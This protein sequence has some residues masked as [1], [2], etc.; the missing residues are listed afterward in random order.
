M[1][2]DVSWRG[3]AKRY[4]DLYRGGA[5]PP[6]ERGRKRPSA[7]SSTAGGLEAA[8]DP[9]QRG[10][11]RLCLF[12]GDRQVFARRSPAGPTASSAASRRASAAGA[13]YGFR[14]DGPFDPARGHRFDAS[15]LL[16][17]PYAFAFDR[18]F[19]LHPSMFKFGEDSGRSRRRRSP[20]RRRPANLAAQRVA[21]EALVI[22]ELNLRGFTR[23]NPAIPEALRGTFAGLAHPASIAHLAALGVTAVEIMPADAF[24]DERHLAAARARNAWG[25]N[26]VV[27]GAPD[28]RLAP[29]GWAEVRA[30][31]D[32]LHARRH[33]GHSRRR[34]QPQRRERR[35]SGRPF[36]SAASTTRPSSVSIPES[37]AITSTT[38]GPA[39]ASRSTD[40]SSSTMAIGALRR[41]MV[42]R[43]LRRVPLRSRDRA[44]PHARTASTRTRRSSRRWRKTR[45]S[46]EARLIAEPWDI[47]PGGYQLGRFG[48]AFAEWN[49]N[50]AT[51]RGASGAA[52]RAARRDRDPHRRLA[53]RLRRCRKRRRRASI[54]SSRMT[55]SPSPTSSPTTGSTTRP[56][57]KEIATAPTPI[58]L[59]P[60]R[61]GAERRSGDDRRAGARRAQSADPSHG[62]ARDADA[63]RWARNSASA[64]A[65]TT[66][67]I[68][69]T[70]RRARSTGA[71]PTRRSPIF[72]AR[73][74]AARR[75][76]P[77]LSRDAFLTGQPF[78][79][80]RSSRR[81]MARRR[82][83]D[84]RSG[85]ERSGG[86][87]SG[88]GLRRAGRGDGVDRAA[89][90]MNRADADTT[91]V[92]P[93]AARRHGVAHAPR[94]RTIQRRRAPARARRP[95]H[96]SGA[97]SRSFSPRRRRRGGCAA[98]RPAA[99]IDALAGAVGIAPDWWDVSGARTFVSPETKI[100]LLGALGLAAA[101]EA[102]ARDSLA[103][104]SR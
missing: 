65:A 81:R 6:H 48:P 71:A 38:P 31:T 63:R 11:R 8:L 90:A 93:A 74:I 53:R 28:P 57:A 50:F 43:R 56:T 4:A 87:G 1:R 9:A 17:D 73:L 25:Y 23:L 51:R 61:R 96:G 42:L 103:R 94:H 66:T 100:A 101:S 102:E 18:P 30:A 88:R 77:A 98:A 84:D 40:R 49:D 39:I 44:R 46:R 62:L 72:T 95:P 10:R 14:V 80:C 47:G 26:P 104:P 54:S 27:F 70:T 79:A 7:S 82:R 37:G 89:I 29:G 60:R 52:I 3:P 97:R 92:L 86:R 59:E 68:P 64:R 69:R 76:H 12:D 15:K 35:S 45:S 32:A 36:P 21:N 33:G 34:L 22:Y 2:A 78:D 85:V 58:F 20:A 16:A 67:P 55:A 99:T 13:R 19:R 75:A 24:V 83:A 91:L 5:S 41:W